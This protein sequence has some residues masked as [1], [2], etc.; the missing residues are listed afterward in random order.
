[1]RRSTL[2]RSL[3]LMIV[4]GAVLLLVSELISDYRNTQLATGAYYFA[5]LAGLTVLAG[6]S[7]QVSLGQGALM[8]VG[9]YTVALLVGNEGWALLPALVAA[10]VVTLIVGV[11]VGVA[12]SRLRGPYLAGAT[13]ALAVGLPALAD[14]VPGHVRRRERPD[15]Q[16]PD[17]AVVCGRGLRPVPLGGVDRVRGCAG[18]PVRAL[19][20]GA[21]R[22]R[23]LVAR[24][25][26]RRDRRL[27]VRHPGG[28]HAGGGVHRQCRLRGPRAAH[29]SPRSWISSPRRERSRS[30]YRCSCWRGWSWEGWDRS[31]V[32]RGEPHCSCSFRTGR[33]TSRTP[34]RCR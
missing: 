4:C 3:A 29:C 20:P 13:L 28:P 26:R 30:S 25:S 2:V 27:A 10:V 21:Q 5:A 17:A 23:A 32:R 6:H 11:P 1:M 31:R 24:G 15:A 7:G 14:Q 8:A 19:Q 22:D 16:S 12:A 34:S 18:G 9:A 33:T